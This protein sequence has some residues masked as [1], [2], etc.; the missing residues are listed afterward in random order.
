MSLFSSLYTGSAGMYA[1]S[2]S[3]AMVANNIANLTTTGYKKSEAY[4]RDLVVSSSLSPGYTAGA[5]LPSRIMRVDEQGSIKQTESKTDAGISGNG[6]FTVKADTDDALPFLYTRNGTFESDSLGILRNDNGFALYAWQLDENGNLPASSS[7]FGSLVPADISLFDNAFVQTSTAALSLNLD[8]D[9]FNIDPHALSTGAQQLPVSSEE[10]HFSRTLTVIDALGT[11]RL[12]TAEFRKVVGPMAHFT[13]NTLGPLEPQQAFIPT[14][15]GGHTTGIATGDQF[16]IFVDGG[17]T[18]TYTFVDEAT[19]DNPAINQIATVQGLI[20]AINLHNG[21]DILHAS[22]TEHGRLLVQAFD[23]TVNVTVS[24][25]TGTPISGANTLNIVPDP[26][27]GTYVFDPDAA[28]TANGTA[29]PN[30]TSFPAFAN[31]AA[32]NIYNWW[33]M[34][35]T[36]PDPAQANLPNPPQVEISKGLLNFDSDGL[37]N[38]ARDGKGNVI[39]AD[40]TLTGIAFDDGVTGEDIDI[41][42][43]LSDLT[44]FSGNYIVYAAEQNGIA[45]GERTGVLIRNNGKIAATFANGITRDMY[46]IPLAT[47]INANGLDEESGTVFRE[48]EISGTPTLNE[49]GFGGAGVIQESAIE[50]SNVDL[51]DE[52]A[53]MIVSQRAFGAS[54]QIIKTVNEMTT[55]LAQLKR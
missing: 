37:L 17:I 50:N 7:D 40:L 34:R 5:V 6:F 20:D 44:Q 45:A 51:G 19:G 11:P 31:I 14:A 13:T 36:T 25:F 1:Q 29:N 9:A 12:V 23:P 39:S 18:E 3:T 41:T 21:G 15:G 4:F 16:R 47:F 27:S 55:L 26:S 48:T 35:L 22:L 32:P 52:F 33:E 54:S 30:Q 49:A 10:A 24:D 46:Q 28:L 42:M 53:K 2:Q 43:D 8:S 38:S